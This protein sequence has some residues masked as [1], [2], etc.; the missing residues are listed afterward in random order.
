MSVRYVLRAN[1]D[2]LRIWKYM[3]VNKSGARTVS[4]FECNSVSKNNTLL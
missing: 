3:E 2:L 1:S 4:Q